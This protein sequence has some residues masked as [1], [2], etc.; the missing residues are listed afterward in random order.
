[1]GMGCNLHSGY[2]YWL[3]VSLANFSLES[4]SSPLYN[5]LNKNK[6]KHS[7]EAYLE[8]WTKVSMSNSVEHSIMRTEYT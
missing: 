3:A 2:F 7:S 8:E 5:T 4:F 6:R 1:M